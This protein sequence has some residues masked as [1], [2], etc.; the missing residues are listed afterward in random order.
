MRGLLKKNASAPTVVMTT[1][2]MVS[3]FGLT[4][5]RV[6]S[7]TRGDSSVMKPR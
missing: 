3:A 7:R 6:S 4:P 1:P 5:N 2:A